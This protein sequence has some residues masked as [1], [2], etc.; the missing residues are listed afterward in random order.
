MRICFT[1][2]AI[3]RGTHF[4]R[5]HLIALAKEKG[6]MVQAR[7]DATTDILVKG[8][9]PHHTKKMNSA[10]KHTVVTYTPEDFLKAMG[11]L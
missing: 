9:V 7:V 11:F 5:K 8:A 3:V 1:G 6:H 10:Y 2:P 4:E